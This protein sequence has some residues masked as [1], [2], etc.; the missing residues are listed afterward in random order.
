LPVI[1]LV[2]GRLTC[3]RLAVQQ[4]HLEI[5]GLDLVWNKIQQWQ[6]QVLIQS[7]DWPSK[8]M[9]REDAPSLKEHQHEPRA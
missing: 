7:F 5:K 1:D 9:A 4:I 6:E 8:L 2:I 3:S